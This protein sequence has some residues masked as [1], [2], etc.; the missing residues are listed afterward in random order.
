MVP[1]FTLTNIIKIKIYTLNKE[2]GPYLPNESD[3]Q[4]YMTICP[5]CYI[6]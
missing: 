3:S 1:I 2:G 5:I 4:N 6:S